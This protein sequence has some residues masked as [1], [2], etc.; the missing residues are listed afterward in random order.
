MLNCVQV[1]LLPDLQNTT[2]L[3]RYLVTGR[4]YWVATCAEWIPSVL[5]YES[6]KTADNPAPRSSAEIQPPRLRCASS[7]VRRAKPLRHTYLYCF[8]K[9]TCEAS[10]LSFLGQQ[11]TVMEQAAVSCRISVKNPSVQTFR[12]CCW[13]C[14]WT[15]FTSI[16]ASRLMWGSKTSCY[17]VVSLYWYLMV[18]QEF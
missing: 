15:V 2:K 14:P 3:P 18:P 1:S 13:I 8:I 17:P 10:N 6:L 12:N 11:T 16:K 5:N 7:A 9:T 4:R